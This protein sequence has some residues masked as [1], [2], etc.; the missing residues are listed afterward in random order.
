[1]LLYYYNT[2]TGETRWQRPAEMGPAPTG[3][4]WFGRGAA[5]NPLSD[6]YDIQNKQFLQRPA[7]QQADSIAATH[8]QR[9]EGAN[10]YNIWYGRYNGDQWDYG[11]E[12]GEPAPFRCHVAKDAG[13]TKADELAAKGQQ[14]FFCIH[15]ARGCCAKGSKCKYYHR[16]SAPSLLH[17]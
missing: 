12:K 8:T 7:R 5:G 4:G 6:V 1:M 11:L 9:K 10:E 3:T 2:I 17:G 15:F 13:Y 14:C 16:Y